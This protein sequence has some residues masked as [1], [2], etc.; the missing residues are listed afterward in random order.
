MKDPDSS[1]LY[2]LRKRISAGVP[3]ALMALLVFSIGTAWASAGGEPA[4]KGWLDTD[5]FRVLNFAVLAVGLFFL[6]RKPLSQ[7]LS[8]RIEEIKEQLKNLETRKAEAEKKL[9][10]YNEKL[11]QLESEAE[12]IVADYIKQGNEAKARI[13]KAAEESAE[14]LQAQAQRN[15]EHEFDRAKKQLQAE[16]IETS[17]AKAETII[18][19][20][21][22]ADDQN[23]LV[24]EYLEKVVAQ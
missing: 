18:K 4:A 11:S 20:K 9:A 2:L 22:S 15:I 5:T 3:A 21:I 19:D 16:I 13:L 24:D 14:K 10:E 17:L 12:K 8:S 1:A 7:A 6:L 23:R